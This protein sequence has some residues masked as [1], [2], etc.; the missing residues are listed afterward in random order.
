MENRQG[1]STYVCHCKHLYEFSSGEM[2][3]PKA[4]YLVTKQIKQFTLIV[5]RLARSPQPFSG[6]HI[7]E[8]TSISKIQLKIASLFPLSDNKG[9][10][11]E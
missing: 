9:V 10:G 7:Y 8:A 1:K 4:F 11:W 3:V 2:L 6:S 5:Q